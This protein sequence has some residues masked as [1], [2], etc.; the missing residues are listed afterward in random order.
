MPDTHPPQPSSFMKVFTSNYEQH[1]P[2]LI[3]SEVVMSAEAPVMTSEKSGL[4][5]L[6]SVPGEDDDSDEI[7][8]V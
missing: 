3:F 6:S 4:L 5:K 2:H 7:N 1:P 8:S